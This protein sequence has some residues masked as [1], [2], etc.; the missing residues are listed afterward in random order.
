MVALGMVIIWGGYSVG[1]YGWCLVRGYD[2]TYGQ[3]LSP[4]H[5]YGSRAGQSWPPPPIPV[6]Q[7]WPSSKG[8]TT[9]TTYTTTA[10]GTKTSK[11]KITGTP[12]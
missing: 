7:V 8:A 10:P 11:P 5:P 12:V 6:G 9:E 2:V 1:L 4:T 3:L